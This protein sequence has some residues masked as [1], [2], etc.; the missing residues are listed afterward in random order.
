MIGQKTSKRL[1]E[2]LGSKETSCLLKGGGGGGLLGG[3]CKDEDS[4]FKIKMKPQR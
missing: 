1:P 3:G 2:I 4:A